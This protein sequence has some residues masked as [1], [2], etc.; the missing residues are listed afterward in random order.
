[1]TAAA[2]IIL[3][4][5]GHKFPKWIW[6]PVLADTALMLSRIWLALPHG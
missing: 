5:S 1:M 6:A 4:G 3:M 2:I